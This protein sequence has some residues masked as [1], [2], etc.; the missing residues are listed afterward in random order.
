MNTFSENGND[1][2]G[3]LLHEGGFRVGPFP[4]F[5][6]PKRPVRFLITGH[7]KGLPD[8]S[9]GDPFHPVTLFTRHPIFC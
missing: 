1:F 5:P 6:K 3:R 9:P 4:H 2:V 8:S 7:K